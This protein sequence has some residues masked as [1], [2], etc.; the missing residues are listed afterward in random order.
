MNDE[1]V[2]DYKVDLQTKMINKKDPCRKLKL[3]GEAYEKG[4]TCSQAVFCAF[5]DEMGIDE[6]IAIKIMEG[7]G[8]GMGGLQ[9]VCG[10]L[11]GAFAVISYLYHDGKTGARD[12]RALIYRKIREAGE[13]FRIEYNGITCYDVLHGEKPKAF[14]CGMKVKDAAMIVTEILKQ[15]MEN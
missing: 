9:E 10:A 5:V 4:Y 8:G 14:K 1:S 3:A 13:K 15:S 12:N 6:E 2:R 7:F 11:S